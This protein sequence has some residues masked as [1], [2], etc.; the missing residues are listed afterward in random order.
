MQNIR[1]L[2][3]SGSLRQHSYNSS[4]LQAIKTLAPDHIKI[5]IFNQMGELPLFNP[6]IENNHIIAVQA[7]KNE[8]NRAN[9]LIIASPEY[10]HGITGVMKNALDWL[11]SGDELPYKPVALI[12]TS[13]RAHHAQ[14]ALREVLNTMS[15][16]TAS[17]ASIN[18]P[19]LGSKLDT[20]GIIEH[21]VFSKDLLSQLTAFY[22]FI[23]AQQTENF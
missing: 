20:Q 14:D 21:A 3:L 12:N 8:I 23:V 6:D 22:H 7:L 9:G 2:C 4:V 1:I 13:P 18:I 5:S 19:L 10:A 17:D 11:V 16:C 15:A